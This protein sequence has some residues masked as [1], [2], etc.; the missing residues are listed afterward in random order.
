MLLDSSKRHIGRDDSND[1][2]V[3]KRGRRAAHVSC[4]IELRESGRYPMGATDYYLVHGPISVYW[5][6]RLAKVR[7]FWVSFSV[8]TTLGNRKRRTIAPR[9][10][11]DYCLSRNNTRNKCPLHSQALVESEK[12]HV[13][14]QRRQ[15]LSTNEAMLL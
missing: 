10:T 7:T 13:V 12:G 5:V 6:T 4:L 14:A 3:V 9:A 8:I 11:F 15:T 1:G 2:L